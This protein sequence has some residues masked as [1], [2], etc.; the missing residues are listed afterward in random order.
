MTARVENRKTSVIIKP[1][2][3]RLWKFFTTKN[4]ITDKSSIVIISVSAC[5]TI[6]IIE[7]LM[8]N[9]KPARR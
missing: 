5:M 9:P 7:K 8:R 4:T 6:D 1:T 3:R 2:L